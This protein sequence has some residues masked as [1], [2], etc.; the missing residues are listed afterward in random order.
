MPLSPA[1]FQT[2]NAVDNTSLHGVIYAPKN[3]H[4]VMML[5][6]GLGEHQGRYAGM[7]AHLNAAGIAVVTLDLRGHGISDGKRGLCRDYSLILGDISAQLA[8]TNEAFP[9]LPTVLYGHSMGGG[10]IL[11]YISELENRQKTVGVIASAPLIELPK[12]I[13]A[14]QVALIKFLR[15]IAPNL[16]LSSRISG[17]MVSTVTAEQ[18]LY[19]ADTLNH[20]KLGVGL[21]QDMVENGGI[22]LERAAKIDLPLLLF[23]A[24]DDCL[25]GPEGSRKFAELAPNCDLHILGDCQHEMHND[26][27]RDAVYAMMIDF[28]IKQSGSK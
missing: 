24:Q 14:V 15:K 2:V 13:P 9:N 4:A 8:K 23:H 17:D 25:T 6:H 10:L 12:A 5:V 7:A 3:P 11:R 1:P 22:I 18:T 21:A 28:I 27:T 16:T 20:T 19:E 26:I